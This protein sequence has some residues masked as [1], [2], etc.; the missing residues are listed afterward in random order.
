MPY[1]SL[2]EIR[3]RIAELAPHLVKW[4]YIESSGFEDLAFKPDKKT[5]KLNNT[6]FVDNVDNYYQTDAISR[7]S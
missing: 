4:D 7:N 5:T 2:D 6:P 3:T 1:D